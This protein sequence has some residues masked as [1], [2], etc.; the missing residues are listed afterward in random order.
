[1]QKELQEWSWYD[2]YGS[3]YRVGMK[4][5]G[6][7]LPDESVAIKMTVQLFRPVTGLME[8]GRFLIPLRQEMKT[9]K[10]LDL[11]RS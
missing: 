3:T 11:R 6:S 4:T 9:W 1:M 2:R 8:T 10:N 7:D 5:S